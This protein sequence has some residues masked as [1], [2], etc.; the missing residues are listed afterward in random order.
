MTAADTVET[1]VALGAALLDERM[2]GWVDRVEVLTLDMSSSCRCVLGWVYA[3][4]EEEGLTAFG[5][6]VR[7]LGLDSPEIQSAHGFDRLYG[8]VWEAATSDFEALRIEWIRV[9]ESRRVSP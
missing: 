9:I 7:E 5:V 6:G 8:L 4:P 1:R 3:A 2:P